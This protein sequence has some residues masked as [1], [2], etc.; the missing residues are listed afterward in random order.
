VTRV[1]QCLLNLLSN[2]CK[3][4]EKGNVTLAVDRQAGEDCDWITFEVRD[5]GI[6]LTPAQIQKLFQAFTQADS[7]TTRKYGGTGLGLV[8]T[9]RFCQMMG[10]DVTVSSVLGQGSTFTIRLPAQP[11]KAP[12]E[13]EPADGATAVGPAGG[14]TVLVV[15][16]DPVMLDMMTR[17]LTKEGFRVV[18]AA[19]GEEALRCAREYRPRAITLDVMMPGMDGWAVL[20][21][22]KADPDLAA[23]P[24]IMLT[25]VDDKNLGFALGA[26]EY[27]SK[28]V[29][30][31][32]LLQ[33]LKKYCGARAPESVLI[34]DD[35]PGFRDMLRRLLEQEGWTVAEA[36]N[37]R[38]ALAELA[39]QR[40]QLILLDLLMPEMNGSEFLR[41]LRHHQEWRT[42]PVV[43]VTAKELS[44]EE[45]REL[46][47][48]VRQILLPA[49]YDRDEVLREVHRLLTEA[50]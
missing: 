4:T 2:A 13:P 31:A 12:A 35:D 27:L 15:D 47:G 41:Q 19:R 16:D 42:I 23:I 36:D 28:P 39:R 40:P 30:R 18:A 37:G 48:P 43:V 7:S 10:G 14:A 21:R 44:E 25:I 32:R 49:T 24:V 29:D 20:S 26:S 45:R 33:I 46:S 34:V 5:S 17:F 1:R 11:P 9:K 50:I 6:G 3:F 22:L 8:I 38:T